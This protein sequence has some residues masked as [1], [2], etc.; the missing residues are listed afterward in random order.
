MPILKNHQ[1]VHKYVLTPAQKNMYRSEKLMNFRWVARILASY[2]SYVL[3]ARDQAEEDL[4]SELAEIGTQIYTCCI[5]QP[6]LNCL[7]FRSI[8]RARLHECGACRFSI[9]QPGHIKEA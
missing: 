2:S 6:I 1:K 8:H 5:S 4:F 3:S 9:K 7:I